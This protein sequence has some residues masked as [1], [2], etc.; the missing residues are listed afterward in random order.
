M[1]RSWSLLDPSHCKIHYLH[2]AQWWYYW[3]TPAVY[4]DSSPPK[5]SPRPCK[6][7]GCRCSMANRHLGLLD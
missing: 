5:S 2:H 7:D 6:S 3:N 1:L 4:G